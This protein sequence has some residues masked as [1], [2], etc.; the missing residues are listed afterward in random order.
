MLASIIFHSLLMIFQAGL[1]MLFNQLLRP[2]LRNL[3]VEVF[4][5]VSYVLDDETY[6]T[7][8]NQEYV[9]KRFVR[10]WETV[11]ECYKVV[12]FG[13]LYIYSEM[14]FE[15]CLMERNYAMVF[16]MAVEMLPRPLEKMTTS[17]KFNEVGCS[18]SFAC[19]LLS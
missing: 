6:S 15:E 9:I 1:D 13:Y 5:D 16:G 14:L 17:M 2:R 12:Q 18:V 11:V 3:I 8:D 10:A 19:F 7:I 4:K